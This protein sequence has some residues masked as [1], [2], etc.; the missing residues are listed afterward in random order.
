M[1]M[2]RCR[3]PD[4]M[5][6]NNLKKCDSEA[7]SPGNCRYMDIAGQTRLGA[8]YKKYGAAA[9]RRLTDPANCPMYEPEPGC[10]RLPPIE[11]RPEGQTEKQA[12]KHRP[13][14][15]TLTEE[16]EARRMGM[17]RSGLTDAEIA[18]E[19]GLSEKAVKSWRRRRNL[20]CV[21][22]KRKETEFQATVKRLYTEGKTDREIAEIIGSK[23]ST[24][25]SWRSRS[26]LPPNAGPRKNSHK[27][28]AE[29][30][31]DNDK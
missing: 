2:G 25:C 30:V 6:R 4:C 12:K 13:P 29:E 11:P 9:A 31:K 17:Y 15:I 3:H 28:K 23:P 8:I 14:G 19:L 26:N 16:E 24:I 1:G 10:P 7:T 20:P 22:R 21:K 27:R 18:A 5:Y